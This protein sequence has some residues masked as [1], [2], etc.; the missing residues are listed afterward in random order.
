MKKQNK[1]YSAFDTAAYYLTFKNRTRKELEDKLT[2]KGYCT[3]DI[4]EAINKLELYGYIDDE[5]YVLSYIRDNMKRKGSKLI[6]MELA[7]KGIDK[8]TFYQQAERLGIDEFGAI[9]AVLR[10]RYRD[11]SDDATRRKAYSYF[12]R[13]GYKSE[14]I[15]RAI[16]Y[17]LKE[18]KEFELQEKYVK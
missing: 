3:A 7:R 2:D 16:S 8:E 14:D 13:K 1:T 9:E 15:N 17:F 18:K 12:M 6:A 11:I 10:K 4:E 5:N